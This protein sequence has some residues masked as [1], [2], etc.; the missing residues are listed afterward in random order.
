MARGN[1][2]ELNVI[3]KRKETHLSI[4]RSKHDN[5][6]DT[7]FMSKTVDLSIVENFSKTIEILS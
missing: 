2:L 6:D 7:A 1:K 3:I 4:D 5:N